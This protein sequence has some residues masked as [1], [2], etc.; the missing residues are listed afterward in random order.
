[1]VSSEPTLT[2]KIMGDTSL[3][4]TAAVAIPVCIFAKPPVP[5][6][7]K[8]RLIPVVGATGAADLASAMLLDV[9]RTV[10]FCAGVRP[11][12]ATTARGDFPI[13]VSPDDVWLQGDGDLGQRIERIL[14]RALLQARGA[15][16]IGADSPTLTA[17][18]IQAAL[19]A[20][21]S[22][23]AVLGPSMDGGFYLLALRKCQHGLFASLPWS[24]SET[25][26]RLK[27]RLEQHGFSMAELEPLFDV[28]IPADLL[29][30]EQHLTADPSLAPATRAW[31]FQDGKT[32]GQAQL[33]ESALLFRR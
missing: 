8:T 11:I 25:R 18:Y 32:L 2:S 6:E 19:H 28:D 3:N 22:N 26:R 4:M 17:A 20:L 10:N 14:T 13:S 12:L 9:W 31:Y 27:A 1:L 15:M 24:T 21:Q 30:L 29:S 7:V 23:D 33:C 16:V 5:G